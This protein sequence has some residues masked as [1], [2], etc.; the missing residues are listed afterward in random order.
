MVSLGILSYARLG[1]Q[2]IAAT[3]GQQWWVMTAAGV[4]NF[5]AFLALAKALQLTTVVYVNA[6]NASQVAMAA[7]AG[8]VLF[9][10]SSSPALALGVILTIGGLMLM[11]PARPERRTLGQRS[12]EPSTE[13][14][15][16][17]VRNLSSNATN[18]SSSHVEN[19]VVATCSAD[20][21]PACPSGGSDPGSVV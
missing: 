5:V 2:G 15:V 3:S 17:N 12:S 21:T 20:Q 7:V 11:R 9:R 13:L 10:E 4:F 19:S 1:W 16:Q 8:V 18:C 6:L 14:C